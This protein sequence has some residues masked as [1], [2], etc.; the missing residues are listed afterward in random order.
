[1]I[2]LS[3]YEEFF[4]LYIDGELNKAQQEAVEAFALQHPHLRAELYKLQQAKLMPADIVSFGDKISLLKPANSSINIENYEEYFLLYTDN[5]L[6]KAAKEET[7]RFVLQHPQLQE[8]FMLLQQAKL[9]PEAA[10]CPNKQALYK[11][12]KRTVP[13]FAR[14]AAAAAFAGIALLVWWQSN[15]TYS[16]QRAVNIRQ[17][18]TTPKA[19]VPQRNNGVIM[20][21]LQADKRTVIAKRETKPKPKEQAAKLVTANNKETA[22]G[23]DKNNSIKPRLAIHINAIP[24]IQQPVPE[25]VILANSIS[26]AKQEPPEL[27][28]LEEMSN[29]NDNDVQVIYAANEDAAARPAVYK[30]LNTDNDAQTLYVGALQLNKAKVNG[31]FKKAAHLLGGKAR[32]QTFE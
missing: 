17:S 16:Q 18:H 29:I 20:P 13:L 26:P 9:L 32:E 21:P 30:E 15:D 22:L 12:G 23:S 31:L 1:M 7:E 2:N 28:P 8:T 24:A 10:E 19:V 14:L 5:E 4:L 25:P 6:T 3:N 27:K 11:K